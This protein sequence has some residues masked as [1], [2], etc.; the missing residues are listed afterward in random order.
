MI[1]LLAC[2]VATTPPSCTVAM[3]GDCMSRP[4]VQDTHSDGWGAGLPME[5]KSL[6]TKSVRHAASL[7]LAVE[8]ARNT[9]DELSIA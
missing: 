1:S 6:N 3:R 8:L 9:F 4:E 5:G 2:I 7:P